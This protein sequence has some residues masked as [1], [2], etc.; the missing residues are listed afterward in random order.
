MRLRRTVARLLGETTAQL[1]RR[2]SFRT[3]AARRRVAAVLAH[4][5]D[6]QLLAGH[7]HLLQ[8][9][10]DLGRHAFGQVQHRM[11]VVDVD[12]A[13]VARFQARLVGDRADDVRRLDAVHVTHLDAEGLHADLGFGARRLV[14]ARTLDARRGRLVMRALVRVFV[15]LAT[16]RPLAAFGAFRTRF[17]H[18]SFLAHGTFAAHARLAPLFRRQ[19]QRRVALQ[20]ARQGGGDVHRRHVVLLLVGFDQAAELAGV[21][22][23]QGVGD[24]AE[25][26]LHPA[27]VD[28]LDAGQLHFLD[29]LA[30]G[31]LDGA[32]HALLA[33]GDEQDRI[34]TAAR[35]AG[36]ADAVHVAFGVVRNVVVQHVADA[37]HV[38]AARG[39]V[40]GHQHVQLAILQLLDGLLALRLLHVAVDGGGG[41]A[42]RL[43]LAC[44]FLG[45]RLGAGEDDHA[46]ERLGFQDSSQRI[47]LVQAADEP[48]ALA[49][50]GRGGGLGRDG[51]LDRILQVGLG[52]AP[53]RRRHG[54]RE[55]RDLARFRGLLQYRLDVVDEAHAQHF[56]GFV[57]HQ[58]GQAGQIQ[59]AALQVIDHPPGGAHHHMHAALERLQLRVVAL[60]AVDRQDVETGHLRRVALE[61]LG[62][63][64]RQFAGRRQ[65]QRLRLVGR[66]VDGGQQRQREG[67]GLAG[68]GLGLAQH[69]AAG[70]HRR[71]GGG[72]DGGWGFVAHFGD[73][74]HDRRG[75]AEIGENERR[76]GRFGGHG[77]LRGVAECARKQRIVR[78]Q[79][80]SCPVGLRV[81]PPR[82]SGKS[83]IWR[84]F[85]PI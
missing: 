32:Q 75:Q 20:Q 12:T 45:R 48:V 28:R 81:A 15:M 85:W 36:A 76:R 50:V 70:Q 25:E 46:V 71:D 5:M 55:Q 30:G 29:R 62:D 21:A 64:D 66:Q 3:L 10:Q 41:Q 82:R 58:R 43:Q 53:D 72:L 18:R 6:A 68:A 60:A 67:R 59:R 83:L 65:H 9:R 19:Q 4:A 35:A 42:A 37:L 38:Q 57:Q 39:H 47:E 22:G 16:G 2:A 34:A 79:A 17:A 80:P 24:A 14:E 63:L 77:G 73:R 54:R 13:D 33:R 26:L 49:D 74:G 56:I 61:R 1:A 84:G 7:P 23:G 78:F 11:V 69:V 8:V 52:D 44:Q 40:G 27:I 31:A 51:D